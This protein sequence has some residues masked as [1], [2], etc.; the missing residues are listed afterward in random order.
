MESEMMQEVLLGDGD[1]GTSRWLMR[2]KSLPRLV[3]MEA[4][5]QV[6]VNERIRIRIT[7]TMEVD[8]HHAILGS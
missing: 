2:R 3:R 6:E 5:M 8:I 1:A 4:Y 7:I